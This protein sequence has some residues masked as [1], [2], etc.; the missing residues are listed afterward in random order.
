MTARVSILTAI[1]VTVVFMAGLGQSS[2]GEKSANVAPQTKCP[3]SGRPV[4]GTHYADV[5]GFRVYTAG[6]QES[7]EVRKNPGRAFAALAKNRE[8]AL[9]L[10]WKCPSMLRPVAP[11]FPYVQ[12]AGKR[13]YY[14]CNPCQSRIKRDFNGAAATMKRLADE[15]GLGQ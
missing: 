9:P 1:A 15:A 12:Q 13:I 5:E 7:E 14:C 2:A 3:I 6:D 11:N 8:A 10:V 4:D